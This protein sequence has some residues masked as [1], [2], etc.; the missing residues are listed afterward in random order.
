MIEPGDIYLA[1][2][3]EERRRRVVI[4]SNAR[5]N[6]G[7]NRVFVIPE[8]FGDEDEVMDPWRIAVEDAVFAVDLLRSLPATR[9]LDR[10]GRIPHAS[11]L[12]M[13]RAVLHL[14]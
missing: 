1:D 9:L 7:S 3:H 10:V 2:L 8:L 14:I 5:F 4:A 11:T 6:R 12:H 13:R